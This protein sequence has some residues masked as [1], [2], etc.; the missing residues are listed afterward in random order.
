MQKSSKS[1][2]RCFQ[3][4]DLFRTRQ[5]ALSASEIA[6]E[7]DAPLS[8]TVELLKGMSEV[9]YIT[10]N[11]IA[12]TFY[13]SFTF[14]ELGS[15]IMRMIQGDTQIVPIAEEVYE[16]I[17]ETTTISTSNDLEMEFLHVIQG[18]FGLTLSIAAGSRLPIFT[19]AVGRALLSTLDDRAI[20]SLA[21]RYKRQKGRAPL[22]K[23][24]I[25]EQSEADRARGYIEVYDGAIANVGAIAM[26]LRIG[27]G[28]TMVLSVGGLSETI[29]SKR[30]KIINTMQAAIKTA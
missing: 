5:V 3:V 7:L 14:A 10:H 6:Q 22:A 18:S 20:D 21:S 15:D 30:E 13:P 12:R 24:A 9:G 19:T 27:T 2:R 16:R 11:V 4:L 17:G 29:R 25:K 28:V 26:P 1:I 23:P 8:S